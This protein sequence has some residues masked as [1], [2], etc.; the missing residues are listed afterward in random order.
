[1]MSKD[2]TVVC[3]TLPKRDQIELPPIA[4]RYIYWFLTNV[5]LVDFS[6]CFTVHKWL[7]LSIWLWVENGRITFW[8]RLLKVS[9]HAVFV[10]QVQ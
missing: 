8:N 9:R 7:R 5:A 1:M 2:A 3:P 4:L 6:Y 10:F